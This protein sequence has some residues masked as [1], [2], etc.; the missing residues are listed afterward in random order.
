MREEMTHERCSELLLAYAQGA[1]FGALREEVE[2]HLDTCSDCSSEYAGL[3]ALRAGPDAE[4]NELERKRLRAGIDSE[5]QKEREVDAPSV[6]RWRR[7]AA[8]LL[9]AAA[10]VAVIAVG[11][12]VWQGSGSDSPLSTAGGDAST[13]SRDEDR[14]RVEDEVGSVQGG[15]AGDP[16]G[17]EAAE[18]EMEAPADQ[19]GDPAGRQEGIPTQDSASGTMLFGGAPVITD[20]P[21]SNARFDPSSLRPARFPAIG[22]SPEAYVNRLTRAVGDARVATLIHECTANLRTSGPPFWLATFA[23]YYRADEILVI[24]FVR[25]VRGSRILEYELRGWHRDCDHPAPVYREGR[26]R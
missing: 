15:G 16:A 23:T 17:E 10:A 13:E 3:S 19:A 26:L 22:A 6:G 18:L 9:A 7:N 21:Y 12:L 2:N 1:L 11:F 14:F 4:L 8:P 25:P 20:D 24:G 5:L